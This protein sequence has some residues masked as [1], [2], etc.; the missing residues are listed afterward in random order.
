MYQQ[1]KGCPMDDKLRYEILNYLHEI[2]HLL[3]EVKKRGDDL[4]KLVGKQGKDSSS[5]Q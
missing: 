3:K 2:A 5:Q 4:W 1:S